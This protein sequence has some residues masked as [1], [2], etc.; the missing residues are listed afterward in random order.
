MGARLEMQVLPSFYGYDAAYACVTVVRNL[1]VIAA[2]D[3]HGAVTGDREVLLGLKH[4]Y[5]VADH[6]DLVLTLD[7]YVAVVPD[8][9]LHIALGVHIDQ[10]LALAV[11]DA[12]F[13]V[14]PAAGSAVA[15]KDALALLGG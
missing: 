1:Q 11:F 3:V 13:V 6:R 2:L 8:V 4:G 15:A 9:L 10:L 12:Q 7:V 14:A 5:A